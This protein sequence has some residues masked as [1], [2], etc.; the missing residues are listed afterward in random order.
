[1]A[2]AVSGPANARWDFADMIIAGR[3][4]ETVI[5]KHKHPA[6]DINQRT[7]IVKSLFTSCVQQAFD[8]KHNDGTFGPA[9]EI[10]MRDFALEYK[11]AELKQVVR[12]RVNVQPTSRGVH[13]C[14]RRINGQIPSLQAQGYPRQLIEKL[15]L[16]KRR[17]LILFGGE[18]GAGKT[19]AASAMI[20]EW[21]KNNG[22]TAITLEDPP[23]YGLQG[24]HKGEKKSGYCM[25]R[26]ANAKEMAAEI[27]SLMRACAPEIIFLGEIRSSDVAKEVLLAASNGHLVVSTIHGKGI[28]GVINRLLSLGTAGTMDIKDAAKIISTSLSMIVHQDLNRRATRDGIEKILRVAHIDLTDKEKQAAISS[29]IR[30]NKI[31]QLKNLLQAPD[32][33]KS[34]I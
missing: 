8:G 22:G 9:G 30:D 11:D 29:S 12:F 1:M 27:P 33:T 23:E 16:P 10:V 31:D 15:M 25:Q 4:G 5:V 21:L 17:G 32:Q 7:D 19:S 3:A 28:E 2:E 24:M 20:S 34:Q 13:F 6:S 14:M 26:H 18:M